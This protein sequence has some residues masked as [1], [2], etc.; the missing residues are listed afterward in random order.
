M[1]F[2][3]EATDLRFVIFN[4]AGEELLG[5]D[6]AALLVKTTLTFSLPNK[7]RTSWPRTGKFLMEFPAYWISGRTDPDGQE[8]STA[9]SYQ[10]GLHPGPDGTTKFL[11]GISEDITER[12]WPRR[13]LLK[14]NGV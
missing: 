12:N 6:R 2:L 1:I 14:A 8:R 11:L 9:A 10:K 3:K 4:R 13:R 7:R 5:Y